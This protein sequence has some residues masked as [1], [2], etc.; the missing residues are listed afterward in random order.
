MTDKKNTEKKKIITTKQ[1][2]NS[3]KLVVLDEKIV[4]KPTNEVL[5]RK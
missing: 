4:L 3:P 5:G 2:D 1:P